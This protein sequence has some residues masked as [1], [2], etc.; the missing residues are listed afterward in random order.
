MA[1]REISQC[2]EKGPM[3]YYGM[4]ERFALLDLWHTNIASRE[5]NNEARNQDMLIIG[6]TLYIV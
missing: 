5:K 6:F 4:L 1:L 3:Q 2:L